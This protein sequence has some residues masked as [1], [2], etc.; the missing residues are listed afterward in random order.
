MKE[1]TKKILVIFCGIAASMILLKTYIS[2]KNYLGKRADYFSYYICYANNKFN[3]KTFE[4]NSIFSKTK[5]LE[6][7]GDISRYCSPK[8]PSVFILAIESL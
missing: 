1:N 8:S 3:H 7:P 5:A 6:L 2:T 4:G